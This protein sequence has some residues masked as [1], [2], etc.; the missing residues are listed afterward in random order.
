MAQ[1]I[2]NFLLWNFSSNNNQPNQQELTHSCK[3]LEKVHSKSSTIY[4]KKKMILRK[5]KSTYLR[6]IYKTTG[7]YNEHIV[8]TLAGCWYDMHAF[9]EFKNVCKNRCKMNLYMTISIAF[10]SFIHVYK[11]KH[12]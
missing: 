4:I 10:N 5:K 6:N 11:N 12:E 9:W 1:Q 2:Y 7:K 3:W 8:N